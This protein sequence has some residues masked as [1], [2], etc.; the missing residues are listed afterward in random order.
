MSG[1]LL[2][3]FLSLSGAALSRSEAL[4]STFGRVSQEPRHVE[5][6]V[7]VDHAAACTTS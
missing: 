6:I 3:Q 7:N 1:N 5:T 2:S 4:F